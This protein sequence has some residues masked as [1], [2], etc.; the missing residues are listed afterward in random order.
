MNSVLPSLLVLAGEAH[1]HPTW[2]DFG[3]VEW[4]AIVVVQAIAIWTIW[5]T[6]MYTIRPGEEEPDH[7]K[8]LIFEDHENAQPGEAL[9]AWLVEH[10]GEHRSDRNAR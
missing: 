8:R 10:H 1:K 5:K 2:A 3:P 6:V 4:V 7:I 9:Q